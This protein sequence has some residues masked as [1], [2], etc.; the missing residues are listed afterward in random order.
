MD[1]PRSVDP[2]NREAMHETEVVIF[3]WL[4]LFAWL[5]SILWM[6]REFF[7]PPNKEMKEKLPVTRI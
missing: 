2:T 7:L 4:I 5:C 6:T 3:G 1:E